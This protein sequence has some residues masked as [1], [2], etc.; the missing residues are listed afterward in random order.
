MKALLIVLAKEL[1]D[2]LRDRRTVLTALLLGPVF[3]PA[4]FVLL[5]G[6][7][8]AKELEK[9]QEQLQL[10]VAGGQHAPNL[11]RY[12][13]Q[14]GVQVTQAPPDPEQAIAAQVHEVV[15]RIDE[16]FPAQWRA[17]RPAK[18]ELLADRSRR[19]VGT[20]LRRVERL[21]GS[22]GAQIGQ[23][24]LTLRGVDPG[25]ARPLELRQ[26]DLSTPESR[27]V[28]VLGMLPYF[29]MLGLFV[30]G[31][32][33]AIDTTAGERERRSLEP[34]L[35]LPV[36]RWQLVGGKLLATSAF[37]LISLALTLLAFAV[38]V[39]L[40]PVEAL[41]ISLN[42]AAPQALHMWLL[43]APVALIAAAL[44]TLLASFARTFR[45][46]QSYMG[47]VVF[48]P[49]IPT[50][51]T[52]ISP[53]KPAL[54]MMAVPLLSQSVFINELIGGEALAPAWQLASV[55]SS[56]LLGLLL[57]LLAI[58]LYARPKLT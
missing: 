33:I 8:S 47:L 17:G 7:M 41:D 3:G 23:L 16:G 15:L 1:R 19:E 11:L 6:V 22:Y 51:W 28:L 37:A 35:T 43:T 12:L 34:L 50:L 53:M 4:L 57:A 55:A 21:L 54:W 9:A 52:F 20:T 14:Q 5:I 38:G 39:R 18:L 36:P 44:L 13:R 2:S 56:L 40:I 25:L 49:L 26:V 30:S 42:L 24:R 46:A 31:M 45:E 10:P 58:R 29:L 48:I 32:S 27:G